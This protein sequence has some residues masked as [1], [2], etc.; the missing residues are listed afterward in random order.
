MRVGKIDWFL[1]SVNHFKH[2]KN[3]HIHTATQRSHPRNYESEESSEP[4]NNTGTSPV[5]NYFAQ[6]G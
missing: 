2:G 6:Q 5:F 3:R 4:S 1:T